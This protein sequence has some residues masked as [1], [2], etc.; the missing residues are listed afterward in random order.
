MEIRRFMH[1]SK[2]LAV[3]EG[4][5]IFFACRNH[6]VQTGWHVL[7]PEYIKVSQPASRKSASTPFHSSHDG[8]RKLIPA[9]AFA[10]MDQTYNSPA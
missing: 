2:Y 10:P 8:Y 7:V 5:F 4:P 9:Q 6:L 3:D 1:M